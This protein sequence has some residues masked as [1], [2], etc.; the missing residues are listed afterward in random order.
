VFLKIR[1][2]SDVTLCQLL[3][4][5]IS[6]DHS[7]IIISEKQTKPA[8]CGVLGAEDEGAMIH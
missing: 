5:S 3:S 1:F 7:A 6:K 2:F 4:G 8:F